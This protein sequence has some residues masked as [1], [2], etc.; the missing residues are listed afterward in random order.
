MCCQHFSVDVWHDP[1]SILYVSRQKMSP[2]PPWQKCNH[3]NLLESLH[4]LQGKMVQNQKTRSL[5][6]W[7]EDF[8]RQ[9]SSQLCVCHASISGSALP[10]RIVVSC[11]R[12]ASLVVVHS[13]LPPKDIHVTGHRKHHAFFQTK[14]ASSSSKYNQY[15]TSGLHDLSQQGSL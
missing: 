1:I 2:Y 13:S 7:Q 8:R 11:G 10:L 12:D 4:D 14:L 9:L 3:N 5:A 6:S 15:A